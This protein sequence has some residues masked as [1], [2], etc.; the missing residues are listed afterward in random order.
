MQAAERGP[1]V[2][3]RAFKREEKEL[4][5]GRGRETRDLASLVVAHPIVLLYAAS[6]AGKSSLLNAG[7][8]PLLEEAQRCEV[9]PPAR[10][11][12]RLPAS[13]TDVDNIYAFNVLSSW[14][15]PS[16]DPRQLLNLHIASFLADRSHQK[17]E[18][19]EPVLRV[20]ILDQ[21]EEL[22]TFAPERWREREGLIRQLATALEADPLL[23]IVLAMREEFIGQFGRHESLLLHGARTRFHLEP[24]GPEAAIDAV[25]GPL[26][27]T[28]RKIEP[29]ASRRLVE[30]LLKIRVRGAGGETV[31][32]TGPFVEPV[33][34]QVA[35]TK[36]WDD[37]PA[38][39]L[40]ITADDVQTF[41][42]VNEALKRFYEEALNAA[43]AK[44][45]VSDDRLRSWVDHHLIT[46]GGTRGMVYRGAESTGSKEAAIPNAA[47]DV[48]EE[49]HLIR[50]E[51]RAGGERWYELTHDRFIEP[52]KESIRVW[53]E[54][55]R[56]RKLRR[57]T[58]IVM[59][60]VATLFVIIFLSPAAYDRYV[61]Y[62][63]ADK[64]VE[65]LL[66]LHAKDPGR[67]EVVAPRILDGVAACL[68]DRNKLDRLVELLQRAER[69]IGE[70]RAEPMRAVM[71]RVADDEKWPIELQY[72][73]ARKLD[74]NRLSY[75]WRIMA[76]WLV[77]EWGIPAPAAMRLREDETI[78]IDY[79]VVVAGEV[80]Q[81]IRAA[82]M[83]GFVLVTEKGMPRKLQTWFDAHK[84]QWVR[85][86]A[87][88]SGGPWW[89]VPQWIQPLL[90]VADHR[91]SQREAAVAGAVAQ[92][93]IDRPELALNRQNVAYRLQRLGEKAGF[94]RTVTEALAARGGIDGLV[95]DLRAIIA[96]DYG[97]LKLEY[98][99][100]SLAGYP[101]S[102]YPPAEV[103][104]LV[105]EDQTEPTSRPDSRLVGAPPAAPGESL[106]T[107]AADILPYRDTTDRIDIEPPVRVYLGED[108]VSSFLVPE[109]DLRPEVLEALSDLRG[110]LF[111]RFGIVVPGVRF[112]ESAAW[113]SQLAPN[114]L[115]IELLNQTRDNRDA[116]PIEVRA[117]EG[118]I[119]QLADEL[120][121]RLLALRTWWI[122]ADYV[123]EHLGP[124]KESQ[125]SEGSN[126]R[127]KVRDWLLN[128]YTLT[129]IKALLRGIVAPTDAEL[130]AYSSEGI[131]G[132][133]RHTVLGQSIRKLD[134]LLASLAFWSQA[135]D[136]FDAAQLVQALRD[137]QAARLAPARTSAPNPPA[138]LLAGIEALE[139]QDFALAEERFR[140]ALAADREGAIA[141]FAPAYA[142]RGA[143]GLQGQLKELTEACLPFERPGQ[144][145]KRDSVLESWRFEIEDFLAR[146]QD[147]LTEPDR[148]RLEY[149]LL[150]HY[151]AK[152]Y[153]AHVRASL[154][155]LSSSQYRSQL[156]PNQK[157][158]LG[159]WTLEF[160]G[161]GFDPPTDL[162]AADSWLVSAFREWKETTQ[163]ETNAG[164]AFRELLD[165]YGGKLPPRW[166]MDMLVRLGGLRPKNFDIA[167]AL[168]N[169]LSRGRDTADADEALV[170]LARA[171]EQIDD[172][173]ARKEDRPR[174][175]A[176]IDYVAGKAYLSR[177]E[178]SS[179]NISEESAQEAT[180]RVKDLIQHLKNE[181]VIADP[182]WP[183]VLAYATLIDIY[184]LRNQF[185]EA[186]KALEASRQDG[187]GESPDLLD[188]QFAIALAEGRVDTAL[189]VADRARNTPEIAS[190]DALFLAALS[191]LL[192]DK[193]EAEFAARQFFAT[194]HQYR[195]YVRLMLYWYLARQG[196][197]GQAKA[198]LDERW[199]SIDPASW[200][201]RL[202]RGDPQV[203]REQLIGYYLGRVK[204]D[205][206]LGP[207]YSREAFETSE[208]NRIGV[209]GLSYE[210]MRC[211]AYFYDAL[212]QDVTGEPA[213]RAARYAQ[214]L[215]RVLEV[216]HG[217]MYE[218]AMAQYLH[219]RR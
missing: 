5:F 50:A 65:D 94:K 53:K 45:G 123:D 84:A 44:T 153:P 210:G 98:L 86:E 118:A 30:E 219:S 15:D 119:K 179:E 108:L 214:A 163:D 26:R 106:T 29:T 104:D 70:Y 43:T 115:R 111:K 21:F 13:L 73:P 136:R 18:T 20:I 173:A 138:A 215:E 167:Y 7:L 182:K 172:P 40:T 164:G 93:L 154:D 67:A 135:H 92:A 170:W 16:V 10:V 12:G 208:L 204:P 42:D 31:E 121:R 11:S 102:D 112:R 117:P 180:S 131:D 101:K 190:A 217:N 126:E 142:S 209:S 78:P 54:T 19:G 49:K 201:A 97:L 1:Y 174:L 137:T 178:F 195:D 166:Y 211:E 87:L 58:G 187:L 134:W 68:W 113:G 188:S 83:P 155:K 183:G 46:P 60:G 156:E 212:L 52:I 33:Q 116:S 205:D 51:A 8:V 91:A 17:D 159:Y 196:K 216:G 82:T 71:P 37:L 150:E 62:Q 80:R 148:V 157:Y 127:K 75:E 189:Q 63:C 165:R 69:L 206:I 47:V 197:L 149:C 192:A 76:T 95:E 175:S 161:R 77:D 140:E 66:E 139:Q 103:A 100:D 202:M 34:L 162:A 39:I 74:D 48:M 25:E 90:E 147:E 35:C 203:W 96:R 32:A 120:P 109:G 193:P 133:L 9:L 158:A 114:A 2:G 38:G 181:G 36:L 124:S 169:S 152:T 27:R 23:R 145:N 6:G 129:D 79:L 105:I 176:W 24:L 72:N 143:V 64:P 122:T 146:H 151:A 107:R 213:T 125:E 110:E 160:G 168:G 128:R 191:Q 3:P 130:D 61:Q 89:E 171:R 14:S 141:A 200:P 184:R 218:Y 56:R 55:C 186:A 99:L 185:D 144:L 132:A 85:T 81:S 4:F 22:F 57:T 194:D 177:A 41:G 28:N 207:L 199:R 198:Y 59:G 88:K